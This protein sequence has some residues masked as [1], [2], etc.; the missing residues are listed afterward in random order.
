MM[1]SARSEEE[2][3]LAA[4]SPQPKIHAL[5]SARFFAALYVVFFHTK[6]GVTPGSALD[7]FASAGYSS[8]CFFFL[9]SGYILADVYLRRGKPAAPRGFYI[10]R[11]AR[12]YPLYIVSVFADAPFAVARRMAAHGL[13]RA[14]GRV[15]VLVTGSV[16]MLQIGFPVLKIVNIPSWSLG[17]ETVFYLSFPFLGP[18]LWRLRKRSLTALGAGLYV[19]SILAYWPLFRLG[20]NPV[21]GLA[22]PSYMAT[23]AL[24]IIIARLQSLQGEKNGRLIT[25]DSTAWLVS[26]LCLMGFIGVVIASPWA[27]RHNVHLGLLLAPVFAASIWVL[28]SS[29]IFP[30]R[31]L[32]AKWLVVLGEASYGLYL[33]HV[34]VL[35]AVTALH[36]SGS[37]SDYP[38]YLGVCI[39]LSV[40]S[41]YFF[42]TPARR[43]ILHRFHTGTKETMEAASSAN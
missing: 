42:E 39:A 36:L 7:R 26:F 11:F 32:S 13:T 27:E 22:L 40:L 37:V 31:W 17:I 6:W 25:S 18:L 16:F 2:A 14:I 29:L 21:P 9:L 28:S 33:I 19:I 30:I 35:H 10:A 20:N 15:L 3:N 1:A 38:L 34:P 43:W 24:G 5:T 12:I 23:F 41:F 8:V 4:R